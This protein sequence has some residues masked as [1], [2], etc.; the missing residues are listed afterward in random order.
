ML[1]EVCFSVGKGELFVV[2]VV[3]FVIVSG[4]G[5]Y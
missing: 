4:V 3:M 2:W 1:C 5:G